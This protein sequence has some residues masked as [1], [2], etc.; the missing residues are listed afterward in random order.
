M[1]LIYLCK[2][3]DDSDLEINFSEEFHLKISNVNNLIINKSNDRIDSFFGGKISNIT[4]FVGR[5]GIGKTT[6]ICGA[7]FAKYWEDYRFIVFKENNKIIIF[8][9]KSFTYNI[10]NKTSY[11]YNE[12]NITQYEL[13]TN[14]LNNLRRVYF[15]SSFSDK[16]INATSLKE[17]ISTV[18]LLNLSLYNNLQISDKYYSFQSKEIE[19]QIKFLKSRFGKD[20]IAENSLNP[21]LV[22]SRNNTEM[23]SIDLNDC[24]YFKVLY[25]SFL[26]ETKF[27]VV[28]LCKFSIEERIVCILWVF[29]LSLNLIDLQKDFIKYL[30]KYKGDF[31][32]LKSDSEFINLAV[33]IGDLFLF[34]FKE[35]KNI[36]T[37]RILFNG[38]IDISSFSISLSQTSFYIPLNIASDLIEI[39]NNLPTKGKILLNRSWNISSGEY[40][41][42]S[43]FSRLNDLYNLKNE[44]RFFLLVIDEGE[45]SFHPEWSRQYL[46]KLINGVQEI[47]SR[48]IGIQIILTTHSPYILSDLPSY[49]VYKIDKNENGQI[50]FFNPKN[51]TFGA[52]IN[53]ILSDSFFM[54]KGLIG[55][56]SK[57]KIIEVIEDLKNDRNKSS[58][59]EE[60]VRGVI[61]CIGEKLIKEKLIELFNSKY[62]ENTYFV[63]K[64]I[65]I[66]EKRL[67]KLKKK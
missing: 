18:G 66:L 36:K 43:F 48:A 7:L 42:L 28:D 53:E 29:V 25:N 6:R 61:E 5:N 39:E 60:Y 44:K 12:K 57:G 24:E 64:E 1:E 67:F 40:S 46:S 8:V 51:Q 31:T 20:F 50:I 56:F 11:E 33:F 55:Q 65:E 4:A 2:L 52:N 45:S 30:D 23:K 10:I 49:N 47:L 15:S 9:N 14:E 37:H 17:D 63:D 19:G 62:K 16:E 35:I 22:Y 38:K 34:F 54:E 26:N 21:D 13:I 59:N 3:E 58:F 27:G 41:F 32:I